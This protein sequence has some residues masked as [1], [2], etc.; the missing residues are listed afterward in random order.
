M[1]S[2]HAFGKL[3][4]NMPQASNSYYSDRASLRNVGTPNPSI[5]RDTSGHQG[6]YYLEF[7]VIWEFDDKSGIAITS[8]QRIYYLTVGR[9]TYATIYSAHAPS[10]V[11]PFIEGL[12]QYIGSPD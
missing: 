10:T 12:S 3:G 5:N 2:Y 1:E 4:A 6:C 9:L 7:H 11:M 8:N